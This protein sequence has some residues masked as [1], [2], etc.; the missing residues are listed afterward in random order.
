MPTKA[1]KSKS[2]EYSCLRLL[3]VKSSLVE[4]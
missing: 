2:L 4:L 1:T 3:M